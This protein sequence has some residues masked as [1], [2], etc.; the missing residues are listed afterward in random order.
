MGNFTTV[1]ITSNSAKIRTGAGLNY[2][3]LLGVSVRKWDTKYSTSDY[4]NGY[5]YI[6]NI[7]GWV[8]EADVSTE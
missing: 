2:S 7:G 3:E 1:T 4:K 6:D 8:S 5:Y